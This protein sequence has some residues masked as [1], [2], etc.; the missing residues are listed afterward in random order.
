MINNKAIGILGAVLFVSLAINFFMAGMVAGGS[1]GGP[2]RMMVSEAEK[3]DTH[4]RQS[5]SDSDRLIL[6]DAMDGNREKIAQLHDDIDS[7]KKN[8]RAIVRGDTLDEKDLG[9]A[10]NAERGKELS[11]LRL[12]HETRKEAMNKMSPEG[13]SVLL[14]IN[15]LGFDPNSQCH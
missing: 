8:M 15:R 5:L 6:R 12:V 11:I 10:L 7:I 4:L 1:F 2:H 14:R 3:Q 9:D 13:R